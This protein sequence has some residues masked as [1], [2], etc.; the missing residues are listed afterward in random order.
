MA[1]A[2]NVAIITGHL[3]ADPEG[4][5]VNDKRKVKIRVA[6]KRPTRNK[7]TDWFEVQ[8]WGRQ[9]EL[10]EQILRKGALA[11][12]V[13][14][15][16]TDT[17]KD[18]DGNNRKSQYILGDNFQVLSKKGEESN[19]PADNSSAPDYSDPDFITADD[20]PPF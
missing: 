5:D 9:A 6:V 1:S 8:L 19:A 2:N 18:K 4:T 13:G 11:Q 14:S 20:P 7:E 3:G 17:W 10:A 16:R 12:F 15:N